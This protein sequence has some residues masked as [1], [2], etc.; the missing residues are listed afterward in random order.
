MNTLP[1]RLT[2]I[3]GTLAL[4]LGMVASSPAWTAGRSTD[5]LGEATRL[6]SGTADQPASQ[7]S[8]PLLAG[9]PIFGAQFMGNTS[10][11]GQA[12]VLGVYW[13][14]TYLG[15]DN[16]EPLDTDPPTYNWGYYD[17]FLSSLATSDREVI[18]TIF[19]NPGWAA[20]N[21]DG[22]I[23]K[24]GGLA[25]FGQFVGALVERYDGDGVDDAPG[26]PQI[27]YWEF[28]NEPDAA[29]RWAG[30]GADYAAMLKTV[31]PAAHAADPTAQVVFGGLAYDWWLP[32]CPPG[33]CW[34]QDFLSTV[35]NN[36]SG[37]QYPYF[38]VLNYHFYNRLAGKWNPPNVVG[39][40]KHL[41]SNQVPVGLRT[42]PV[43]VT[44]YGEPFSGES[45]TPAYS[46]Q[47]ASRYAVQGTT[48]LLAQPAWGVS[49]IIGSI[50]FTLEY[51]NESP[52]RWG[53]L[54]PD[55]SLSDEGRAFQ[56]TTRELADASFLQ[57]MSISGVEG[58]SF[59]ASGW[60]GTKFVLWA[61]DFNVNVSFSAALVRQVQMTCSS[62]AGPCTWSERFVADGSADDRDHNPHNNAVLLSISQDPTFVQLLPAGYETP[63][64]TPTATNTPTPTSTP[65]ETNTPTS[66]PT[67][68]ETD[69]PTATST[70][71][72]TN[73]ATPTSTPTDTATATSTAPPTS[74]ATPTQTVTS[75]PTT[76]AAWTP[77]Q[78][79][80]DVNSDGKVDVNDAMDVANRWH[81]QQAGGTSGP[82]AYDLGRDLDGDGDI[83][84]VDVM[85]VF[86]YLGDSC[87]AEL[88]AV[89]FTRDGQVTTDDVM[90][91]AGRW[92]AIS[93][94][95]LYDAWRDLNHN[96]QI[97]AGDV[98][99]VAERWGLRCSIGSAASR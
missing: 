37:S 36:A 48:Q 49:T 96:D 24:P 21:M 4:L 66:T 44:E 68:T 43:L 17:A 90:D 88:Y 79:P 80:G 3:A 76:P 9:D 82:Y 95:L 38:D 84:S 55:L 97:D 40:L 74:T 63:T 62:T 99:I 93:G 65:T 78:L 22:P 72:E 23:D 83:D 42:M 26:S 59:Q 87:P 54:Q 8:Q 51:Y 69:T 15:W 64:P 41:L 75:T 5:S 6:A 81:T 16:I 10:A 77:Y 89:D 11:L 39:K 94:Q 67:P 18:V 13:I 35:I 52:R 85:L 34:D 14:R 53:L 19:H 2:M 98:M 27:R 31:Y 1:T 29:D 86:Q 25:A 20:T 7:H 70:P 28:Y 58:Y 71:T 46:H 50:W 12:Q 57:Q 45:Q 91:V 61:T 30:H 33:T 47:I 60:P 73:T 56:T 32:E 92:Q